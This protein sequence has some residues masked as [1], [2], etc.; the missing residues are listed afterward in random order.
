MITNIIDLLSQFVVA[1]IGFSGYAGVFALMA[2]ESCGVPMPSEVIMPFSGF[3]VADGRMSFWLLVLVGTMGNLFGSLVAYWLGAK[4]GRPLIEKYG[5][6]ILISK[7]D[8]DLADKWFS[9][10]GDLTVFLGRLLPVIRTYISF[11]AGIAKMDL[12]KFSFYT[13]VGAFPWCVLFAWL[14]VKMGSN[15]ELVKAKLHNFDLLMAALV[16]LAI[17]WYIWRHLKNRG[18]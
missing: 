17:G 5:K 1:V 15:W 2:L 7:H 11:P 14:G 12:K 13:F 18:K 3:L 10:Y 9:T 6:Y 8:L 16:V 4:G